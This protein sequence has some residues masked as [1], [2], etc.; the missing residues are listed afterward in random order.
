MI[1][2]SPHMTIVDGSIR[3]MPVSTPF[4]YN[5]NDVNSLPEGTTLTGHTGK[6]TALLATN[7]SQNDGRHYLLSGSADCSVRVWDLE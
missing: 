6:V 4:Y 7:A 3:I 5:V 2:K 1:S